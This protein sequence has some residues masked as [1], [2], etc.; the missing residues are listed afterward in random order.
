MN[1]S[2]EFD[3]IKAKFAEVVILFHCHFFLRNNQLRALLKMAQ[4]KK[5]VN[6]KKRCLLEKHSNY[7][8]SVTSRLKFPIRV[9]LKNGYVFHRKNASIVNTDGFLTAILHRGLRN[10]FF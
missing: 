5:C 9:L 10:D 8:F 2:S 6:E 1:E 4:A 3:S 7:D